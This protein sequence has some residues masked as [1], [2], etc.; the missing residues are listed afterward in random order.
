MD[1]SIN[2]DLN[3]NPQFVNLDKD[4]PTIIKVIGVGGGGNNAINHMYEQDIK[5]VRFLV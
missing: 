2:N 5:G 1:N 4:M 3:S